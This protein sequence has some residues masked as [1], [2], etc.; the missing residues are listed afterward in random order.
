MRRGLI[1]AINLLI[2]GFILFFIVRYAN[3]KADESYENGIIAF[4]KMTVTTNQI[5]AN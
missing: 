5:I 4:E 1:I 2:M 3:E